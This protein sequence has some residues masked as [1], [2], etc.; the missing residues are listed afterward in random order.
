M[1]IVAIVVSA[2]CGVYFASLINTAPNPFTQREGEPLE[3]KWWV[4]VVAAFVTI[5]VVL[6]SLGSPVL[7]GL[8]M[9]ALLAYLTFFIKDK[10]TANLGIATMLPLAA[11]FALCAA[12]RIDR[13]NTAN[14]P[15]GT[16]SKLGI[17]LVPILAIALTFLISLVKTISISDEKKRKLKNTLTTGNIITTLV[18]VVMVIIV[19]ICLKEVF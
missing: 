15:V 2:A 7:T 13:L 16:G 17:I 11:S 5:N 12:Q 1:F 10:L 4:V 8:L 9:V 3:K 18:V 19:I 6:V 14:K